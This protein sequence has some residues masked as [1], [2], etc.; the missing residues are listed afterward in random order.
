MRHAPVR[1]ENWDKISSILEV[2]PNSFAGVMKKFGQD[3]IE[4]AKTKLTSIPAKSI[5]I[6]N[7]W[8]YE[9]KDLNQLQEEGQSSNRYFKNGTLIIEDYG[10]QFINGSKSSDKIII[11]D[12]DSIHALFWE[13]NEGRCDIIFK[14][15][16]VNTVEG[17]A[18]E[19]QDPM[20]QL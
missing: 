6:K 10:I 12:Y 18:K 5:P 11:D 3:L 1:K 17:D 2:F 14:G 8:M 13:R 15:R 7:K 16:K 4:K 19:V 20:E 9:F